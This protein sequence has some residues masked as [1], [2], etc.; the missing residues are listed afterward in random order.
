MGQVFL[1]VKE[2]IGGFRRLVVIKRLLPKH[3]NDPRTQN[4][5]LAEARLAATLHHP[6]VVQI[7]DVG[8]DDYGFYISMEYLSG[9]NLQAVLRTLSMRG[10]TIP[11]EFACEIGA[12]IAAG[13]HS[14]HTS[15]D[16]AGEV[17]PIVHRDVT[18][19]NVIVCY[20]GEVK[21]VDFGIAKANEAE[22]DVTRPGTIKGKWAYLSPEQIEA[23]AITPRTDVFQLGIVL[24]EMLTG[25]RLF[26]AE[27]EIQ[28]IN[29][30]MKLE[31]Q[32]PS[33][34]N[35]DVP[36][37]L[38][39]LVLQMLER[40]PEK[41]PR[42]ADIVRR[43]LSKLLKDLGRTVS[44]EELAVWMKG[45]FS[46]LHEERLAMERDCHTRAD[47][48]STGQM[49]SMPYMEDLQAR[50]PLP[51]PAIH[52]GGS[53]PSLSVPSGSR[54][55]HSRSFSNNPSHSAPMSSNPNHSLGG[56]SH[57][58]THG[59]HGTSAT[60]GHNKSPYIALFL[61]V[62]VCGLLA[63]L[64]S[65]DRKAPE[66]TP[67]Y[68]P[69]PTTNTTYEQEGVVENI[70]VEEA[71]AIVEVDIGNEETPPGDETNA[72]GKSDDSPDAEGDLS[73]KVDP[74]KDK[75]RRGKPKNN[76]KKLKDNKVQPTPTPPGPTASAA[77]PDEKTADE[78]TEE[79]EEKSFIRRKRNDNKNPWRNR[80]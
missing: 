67:Q 18:P 60:G 30:V 42:S 24:H 58:G 74:P 33:S 48:M 47:S 14:A 62:V 20:N 23:G 63:M 45:A 12:S 13:L 57:G 80:K 79:K 70:P 4:M 32:P 9:E 36:E 49:S 1:T 64:L 26:R 10:G 8:H 56:H 68:A 75:N 76:N 51:E 72:E 41:R 53:N 35:P 50:A 46:E 40:D 28:S 27:N 6:N 3:N 43:D 52:P 19:G 71:P 29:A 25:R 38:D 11:V 66:P 16:S 5:F 69:V 15:T 55:Q 17:H 65:G 44:R 77:A 2:G 37:E 39:K 21:I 54:S 73:A 22:G 78:P 7:F 31:I 34:I 59:T 61:G